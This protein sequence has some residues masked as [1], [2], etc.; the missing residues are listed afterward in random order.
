MAPVVIF[1]LAASVIEPAVLPLPVV[2][3]VRAFVIIEPEDALS[4]IDPALLIFAVTFIEPVVLVSFRTC[5][6][7]LALR[8][9]LS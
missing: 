1:V 4:E 6:V 7:G 9:K 5:A 8:V 3:V 2:L